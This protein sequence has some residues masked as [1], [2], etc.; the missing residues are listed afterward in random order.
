DFASR[1]SIKD[2]VFI[3]VS[4]LNGDNVV[5]P[6]KNMPWYSGVTV[7]YQLENVHHASDR[8]LIDV[9]FPVQYVIRPRSDAQHDYRAYAG[10]VAG[11][12]LKP[13]DAVVVLPRDTEAHIASIGTYDGPIDAAFPPVAFR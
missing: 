1:L 10:R 11:G 13:T 2:V 6:S 5:T 4:A 9:R 12:V 8:D 7:L 3:P